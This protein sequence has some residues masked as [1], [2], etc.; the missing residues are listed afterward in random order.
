MERHFRS[1]SARFRSQ[2]GGLGLNIAHRVAALH[3]WNMCLKASI[4]G[5]LVVSFRDPRL[6]ENGTGSVE[7]PEPSR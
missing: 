1:D 5:G 4:A 6:A 3:G 7:S 2:G